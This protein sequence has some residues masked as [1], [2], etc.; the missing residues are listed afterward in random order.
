MDI[1]VNLDVPDL[2]AAEALYV[3]AFG[4]R[5]GRRFGDA[6]VELLGAQVPVYLLVKS[7]DSI[8]AATR[9]RDYARHW[10]PCHLDVV[11]D[12]LAAALAR[13]LAAGFTQEG[14]VRE[15]DWG[16]IVQIADPFGHGWCLLQFV[17]RGY[18]E[19]ASIPA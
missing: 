7:A 17:G 8:G 1:L 10:M 14:D 2:A 13:V 12:D 18:D 3:A 11:V 6:G 16:R 4:L 5:I 19:I 9:P 15:A